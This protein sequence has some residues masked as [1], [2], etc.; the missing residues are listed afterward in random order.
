MGASWGG[1]MKQRA[2]PGSVTPGD[3]RAAGNRANR[4]IGKRPVKHQALG[5]QLL[6]MRHRRPR[7]IE[8]A[9]EVLRIIL[10]G[11]PKNVGPRGRRDRPGYRG[12]DQCK[13][14]PGKRMHQ[15]K[16]VICGKTGRNADNPISPGR[17]A[18]RVKNLSHPVPRSSPLPWQAT[19]P[20]R[21]RNPRSDRMSSNR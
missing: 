18:L 21:D 1:P 4:R 16:G 12:Q 7:R 9:D 13:N 3:Q 2:D 6:K 8:E 17:S 19:T 14:Q 20:H 10:R 11:D 5:S 15:R